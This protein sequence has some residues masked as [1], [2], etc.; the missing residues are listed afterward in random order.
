MLLCGHSWETVYIIFLNAEE[1]MDLN[2]VAASSQ[3]LAQGNFT[4]FIIPAFGRFR[5]K[6]FCESRPAWAIV[7][8]GQSGLPK[9]T[10]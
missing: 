4:T 10:L 5:Q 7:G 2:F 1:A 6:G 3:P 9:K 8:L